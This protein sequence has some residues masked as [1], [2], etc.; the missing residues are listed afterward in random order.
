MNNVIVKRQNEEKCICYLAAQRQL[1]NEA[2]RLD[3]IEILFSVFLPLFFAALQSII[4]GNTYL[5]ATSYVLSIVSMVISLLFGSYIDR[6]KEIAAEIQQHFDLYVYQMPWDNK[7]FC[8]QRNVTHVVAEKA[9]LLLKNPKEHERLTNWYTTATETVDL[10]K[11]ILMCQKE[12]Y[13]WDVNLRKR[14]RRLSV[15]II[16]ILII[17]IFLIGIIKNETVVMLLCRFAF[18]IPMLQWLFET[19]KQLNKDIK[20]LEELDS[21]ISSSEPKSMDEL[22]MIQSKIYIHRKSCYTIPNKFYDRYKNNDED[23]AHRTA[24]LDK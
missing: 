11:G 21:L 14:F 10:K 9:K 23:V 8:L 16:I 20:N 24:L 6:K 17:L 3:N 5:N 7:L 22:H 4:S 13:N 12:N 15:I 2:K 1:Y 19:V 18:I